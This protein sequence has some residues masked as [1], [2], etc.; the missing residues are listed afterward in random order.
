[1]G[2]YEM[3]PD[4]LFL[5]AERREDNGDLRGAFR[6]LLQ[7][8]SN[9]H[10]GSQLNLGNYYSSGNGIERDLEE[11]AKW[12]R[13]AYRNGSSAGAA[14]LAIDL[15]TAGKI[16]GAIKW[17]KRA[18]EMNDGDAWVEL[19]RLLKDR[20]RG[21]AAAVEYL[22]KAVAMSRDDITDDGREEAQEL[23]R[24]LASRDKRR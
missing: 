17:I 15:R 3:K 19:A 7:A 13:R 11:A 4:E 8:A 9:G 18:A 10:A 12:Y 22:K 24:E 16:R 20:P 23:L 2:K 1:M 5:E 21:R 6:C 14:N